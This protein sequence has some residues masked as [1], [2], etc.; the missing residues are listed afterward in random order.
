MVIAKVSFFYIG[1]MMP[2]TI[3]K[4]QLLGSLCVTVAKIKKEGFFIVNLNIGLTSVRKS[5]S[6]FVCT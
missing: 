5:I 1:E 4:A 3:K 6:Q 2:G